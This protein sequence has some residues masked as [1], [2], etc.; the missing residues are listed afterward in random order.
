MSAE[1]I[2]RHELKKLLDE[3]LSKYATFKSLN[4]INPCLI[5]IGEEKFYIYIKNI[6]PTAFPNENADVNRIQLPRRKNFEEI[7]NS[8]VPFVLLGYDQDNDVYVTWNPQ[9]AKNR[10]NVASNVSCYSRVATQK[11]ARDKMDF[12]KQRLTNDVE[13]VAFPREFLGD[14]LVNINEYFQHLCEN[15]TLVF[16]QDEEDII[17][18]EYETQEEQMNMALGV[19]YEAMYTDKNTGKLTRLANPELLEKIRPYLIDS[20]Y[21]TPIAAYNIIEDFYGSRYYNVMEFTDWKNLIEHINWNDTENSYNVAAEDVGGKRKTHIIKVTFPDGSVI[22]DQK[23]CDTMVKVV[24]RAGVEEVWALD[25][26]IN[27]DNMIVEKDEIN[28][29]YEIATK[30]VDNGLYVNTSSDTNKNAEILQF[31]SNSL[32]LDLKVELVSLDDLSTQQALCVYPKGSKQKKRI[33]VTFPD[34]RS[35][36]P[37]D[38]MNALIEVVKYADPQNVRALNINCNHDNLIIMK[39]EI[40]PRYEKASKP[41]GDGYYVNTNSGTDKKHKQITQISEKLGLNLLVELI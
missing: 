32:N 27:G 40:N 25:I 14:Y 15:T 20:E 30:Y 37:D 13:F 8:D 19:D 38:V 3:T 34:G 23:V 7:K 12:I 24:K 11:I 4:G 26:R 28:P 1:K 9:W 22:Q 39:D 31:I 17:P 2:E 35:I 33:R 5:V 41:V 36:M 16:E 10:L 29:K 21:K 6:T 18:V